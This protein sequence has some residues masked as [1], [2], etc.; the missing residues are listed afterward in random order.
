MREGGEKRK[1]CKARKGKEKGD[2][3]GGLST[4]QEE[5]G[6][7]GRGET[8]SDGGGTRGAW[9]SWLLQAGPTPRAHPAEALLKMAAL[10]PHCPFPLPRSSR[11][12]PRWPRAGASRGPTLTRQKRLEW[13]SSR[14]APF[15]T[16]Q[17]LILTATTHTPL[18]HSLRQERKRQTEREREREREGETDSEEGK[19]EGG[20]AHAQ[21]IIQLNKRFTDTRTRNSGKRGE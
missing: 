1:S 14:L 18:S 2:L 6:R 8:D 9:E 15:G 13:Q 20:S 17:E 10:L 12:F 19:G 7:E 11:P 21:I 16:K 5:S 4:I 3:R